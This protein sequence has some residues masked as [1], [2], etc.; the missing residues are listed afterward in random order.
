M[1][2]PFVNRRS[3][4]MVVAERDELKKK[5][6]DLM[7]QFIWRATKIP[8]YP[9]G[10]PVEYRETLIPKPVS[11]PSAVLNDPKET[12]EQVRSPRAQLKWVADQREKAFAETQGKLAIVPEQELKEG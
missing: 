1:N 4:E 12:A 8:L 5:Y 7:N 6:D 11:D 10:L 9:E 3:F 2:W